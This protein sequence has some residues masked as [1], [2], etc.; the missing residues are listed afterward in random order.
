MLDTALCFLL[1]ILAVSSCG[2]CRLFACVLLQHAHRLVGI[3]CTMVE[4]VS[5]ASTLATSISNKCINS[6]ILTLLAWICFG[7]LII[8]IKFSYNSISSLLLL[9]AS[10]V[11]FLSIVYFF[12]L[13]Y[14]FLFNLFEYV[15]LFRCLW[16]Q[17]LLAAFVMFLLQLKQPLS[18][19]NFS[20][21]LICLFFII[22]H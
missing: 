6:F 5:R 19:F 15:S 1:N 22:P 12:R 17:A 2:R 11:E 8:L 13:I 20:I 4:I 16:L 14:L 10:K 3:V 21:V 9:V 7:N 18:R